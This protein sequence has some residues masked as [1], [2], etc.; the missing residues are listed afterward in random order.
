M[1]TLANLLDGVRA[2]GAVF[3]R[4]VMS[5]QLSLRFASGAQLTLA[6]ALDGHVWITPAHG[7]P[8]HLDAGDIAV[9]RGPAPYTVA[10]NP[11]VP[12]RHTIT[13]ADYCA[14]TTRATAGGE[15][16]TDP[17]T[18]GVGDAGS[19]SLISGAYEGRTGIS[20]RL[21]DA[22]PAVL[23]VPEEDSDP[24]LLALVATEL[25]RDRP[26]QQTV[27]DRL[28]DLLLVS[29]LRAW[30]DR[31]HHQ[32]PAWYRTGDDPV[33]AAALRLMHEH[34][35]HPWTVATLAAKAGA[36][37]SGLARRFT[38]HVGQPPMS[39]LASWRT[40]LAADL[41]R[42]TDATVGAIARQ[43]GYSNTFALSVAFKRCRGLTSTE[44]RAAAQRTRELTP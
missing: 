10:E 16:G 19:V 34:P 44:H 35:A 27:P 20:D 31:P 38:Q 36:S 18:C 8:F 2:R 26:G 40:A 30:F 7:E 39:Y 12:P 11:A 14:S 24:T 13:S 43:V 5:P 17:R 37:R 21:L 23:V 9:L 25:R 29:T 32:A 1:D 42:D 41:L 33:V 6:A 4:T 22:L 28:L 3:T 15:P